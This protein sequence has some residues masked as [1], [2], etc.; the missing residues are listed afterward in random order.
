MKTNAEVYN[1]LFVN[2]DPSS[3][4]SDYG[5]NLIIG[6][7]RQYPGAPMISASFSSCSGVGYTALA[8]PDSI[9]QA[10]ISRMP[11]T[12]IMELIPNK[13]ECFLV[14]QNDQE[15]KNIMKY[16]S[17]LFGNGVKDDKANYDF[18]SFLIEKYE[19]RLLIDAT[20]L[21]LLSEYG[22]DVLLKKK[23]K[24]F[25]VLTPHLGE[26]CSLFNMKTK[27][28]KSQDYLEKTN[29]FTL[30]YQVTILLKSSI[31]YLCQSGKNILLASPETPSLAKAGSGDGLAGFLSGVLAY[32]V[33]WF[34]EIELIAFVNDFIHIKAHECEEE[35]PAGFINIL[36]ILKTL[37]K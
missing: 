37:R 29:E 14:P 25:I 7:S 22:E 16:D 2:R 28:N 9:Y 6:G 15:K 5:R 21:R 1:Q 31:S 8:V 3:N 19:G 10:T 17:I 4:K 20:G 27:S 12:C 36:N 32:G 24:S 11:L 13:D 26:A 34:N 33:K 23:P 18:L 30:K 35:Q